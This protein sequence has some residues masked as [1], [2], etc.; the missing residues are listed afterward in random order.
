[1]YPLAVHMLYFEQF[2]SLCYSPLHFPPAS[3]Y[4]TAFSTYHYAFCLHRYEVFL[5][6]FYFKKFLFYCF[7]VYPHICT[8]FGSP[9]PHQNISILYTIIL[10][11]ASSEFHS[12]FPLCHILPIDVY[13]I[14]FVFIYTF[15]FWIYLPH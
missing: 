12:V 5:S 14:M 3:H 11:P 10:F 4:L 1:M 6:F 8:L 13:M 2:K 7:Y 15:I 9:P